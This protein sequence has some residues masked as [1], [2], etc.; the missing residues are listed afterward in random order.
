M[1]RCFPSQ[2]LDDII[3]FEWSTNATLTNSY[4]SDDRGLSEV[5]RQTLHTIGQ[6]KEYEK[7]LEHRTGWVE[8]QLKSLPWIKSGQDDEEQIPMMERI[9][10]HHLGEL[11]RRLDEQQDAFLSEIKGLV[12]QSRILFQPL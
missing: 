6:C 8:S 9:F 2:V 1:C 5:K 3:Y 7:Y 10:A 12:C 4:I 11:D